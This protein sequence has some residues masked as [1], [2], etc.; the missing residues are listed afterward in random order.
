MAPL[1]AI[2]A[3]HYKSRYTDTEMSFDLRRLIGRVVGHHIDLIPPSKILESC[4]MLAS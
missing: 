1:L 2:V 4:Q 3:G